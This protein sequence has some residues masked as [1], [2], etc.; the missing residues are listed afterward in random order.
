LSQSSTNFTEI[1]TR[2][3]LGSKEEGFGLPHEVADE[4]SSRQQQA[5]ANHSQQDSLGRKAFDI[6]RA[7][8]VCPLVQKKQTVK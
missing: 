7:Q 1:G 6:G 4:K 2:H 8:K 5:I 3:D